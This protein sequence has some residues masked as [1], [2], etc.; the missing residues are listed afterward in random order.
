M[1]LQFPLVWRVG[2]VGLLATFRPSW[3][4]AQ[5]ELILTNNPQATD[6]SLDL[7]EGTGRETFR[8]AG[9]KIR[10]QDPDSAFV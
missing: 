4:P 1:L 2:V 8:R 9:K 5:V 6:H 10:F 3:K 7:R